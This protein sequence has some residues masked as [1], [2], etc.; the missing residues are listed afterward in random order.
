MAKIDGE[1][2]VMLGYLAGY[3]RAK[4]PK[5]RVGNKAAFKAWKVYRDAWE[6]K[7]TRKK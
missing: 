2:L 7:H 1:D 4:A 3:T 5:S 6:R